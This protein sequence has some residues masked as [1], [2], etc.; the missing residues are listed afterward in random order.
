MVW[1]EAGAEEDVHGMWEDIYQGR[2][3][4]NLLIE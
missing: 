4:E 3:E 1:E 2:R